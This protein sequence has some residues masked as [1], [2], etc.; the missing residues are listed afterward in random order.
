MRVKMIKTENCD[1][2]KLLVDGKLV[3]KINMH[4]ASTE[5]NLYPIKKHNQIRHQ[6]VCKK[7]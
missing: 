4:C 1:W 6:N 2:D 3:I 7:I 5:L